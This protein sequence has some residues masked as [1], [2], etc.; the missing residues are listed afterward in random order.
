MATADAPTLADIAAEVDAALAALEMPREPADLYDPTRYVLAGGGK[1]IRPALVLLAADALGGDDARARALSPA[2]G[3]EVFHNFTLVHDD[4]MDHAA[5]RRGRPTVHERWDMPTAILTGDLLMGLANDLVVRTEGADPIRLQ[6][7]FYDAVA[8]LCEGQTLDMAFERRSDVT[9]DEYIGMID[10]K[11]GALLELALELGAIVGGAPDAVAPLRRAG[12]ALGRAF[13]IQDDLL[14]LTASGAAWGKA[15]GGDLV[16]GKRTFLIVSAMD[17]VER[18]D[19]DWLDAVLA[20]TLSPERVPEVRDRLD[21]LGVLDAASAHVERYTAE[22][23][24]GLACLPDHPA[25][26]ALRA[27]ARQLASRQ[28]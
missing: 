5:T 12:R 2:L 11:T 28:L 13:Q 16:E 4:I 7:A 27:L 25:A 20:G 26:A 22:A 10:R 19:R 23:F 24:D 15:L 9:V 14:D 18:S 8:R 1:R 17:R 6:R 3:V 21:A